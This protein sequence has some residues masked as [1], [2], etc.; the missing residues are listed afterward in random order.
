MDNN[1]HWL[2]MCGI[3]LEPE[4]SASVKS[5][6]SKKWVPFTD[7]RRVTTLQLAPQHRYKCPQ[8]NEPMTTFPPAGS[9]TSLAG[10]AGLVLLSVCFIPKYTNKPEEK[11][12]IS[13]AWNSWK[14]QGNGHHHPK[15][16]KVCYVST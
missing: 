7:G 12:L 8:E 5:W 10:V 2:R 3:I 13:F 14:C 9:E 16:S 11:I 6:F 1:K 15:C 4:V